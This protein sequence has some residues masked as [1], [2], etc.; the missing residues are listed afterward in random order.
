M[1]RGLS[2]GQETIY[3]MVSERVI[4][5]LEEA[6][7]NGTRVPWYRPWKNGRMA[8]GAISYATRQPYDFTN[9]FMLGF[10]GTW[11]SWT[12]IQRQEAKLK[13]GA[14]CGYVVEKFLKEV[15]TEVENDE[16][17]VEEKTRKWWNLRYFKVYNVADVE[18][19]K[20]LNLKAAE[21]NHADPMSE[22]EGIVKDYEARSGVKIYRERQTNEAYYSPVFDEIHVP[23]IKQYKKS[24]RAEYYS[25]LFHEMTHSTGHS[26]RLNRLKTAANAGFGSEAYSQEELIAE[27]GAAV[28]CATCGVATDN[29]EKNSVAYLR[30]WIKPLK[31]DVTLAYWACRCAEKA[32]SYILY[33]AEGYT[34][35]TE[36][37]GNEKAAEGKSAAESESNS[38]T[39]EVKTNAE[40]SIAQPKAE[41][42]SKGKKKTEGKGKKSEGKKQTKTKTEGKKPSAKAEENKTKAKEKTSKVN[43]EEVYKNTVAMLRAYYADKDGDRTFA[44]EVINNPHKYTEVPN[45]FLATAAKMLIQAL[46]GMDKG[47]SGKQSIAAIKKFLDPKSAN[48]QLG[49]VTEYECEGKKCYVLLDGHKLIRLHEDIASLPHYTEPNK[50]DVDKLFAMDKSTECFELPSV[51]EIKAHI[52]KCKADYGKDYKNNLAIN[53]GEALNGTKV[54]VNAEYLLDFEGALPNYRIHKAEKNNAAMY[55]ESEYGDGIILPIRVKD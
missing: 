5:A 10:S 6:I 14:R 11:V 20:P 18:G 45:V 32:V 48:R 22:A 28:L 38:K 50:F 36:D 27:I 26:T 47:K 37:E 9:Q 34:E 13:E 31:D 41:G 1:A 55:V 53:I 42:K 29:S 16:G 35:Q 39:E 4:K 24:K 17:E 8:G 44:N 30:S 23:S 46:E 21:D 54:W 49:C 40:D 7:N 15:K 19:L 25:T 12:E 52:A 2:K 33:G 51:A 43:H 3:R